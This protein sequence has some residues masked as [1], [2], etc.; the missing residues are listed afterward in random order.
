MPDRPQSKSIATVAALSVSL[1]SLCASTA[2]ADNGTDFNERRRNTDFVRSDQ[3]GGWGGTNDRRRQRPGDAGQRRPWW[4]WSQPSNGWWDPEPAPAQHANRSFETDFESDPEAVQGAQIYDYRPDPLVTLGD[5]SLQWTEPARAAVE[6]GDR[7]VGV[8]PKPPVAA[9]PLA[10]AVFDEMA[11]RS[12]GVRVTEP[13]SKAI[14]AF[15][16]ARNF[17]PIWVSDDA[18]RE[19]SRRALDALS[20]AGAEGLDPAEYLPPALGSFSDSLPD[21]GDAEAAARFELGLTAMALRY[22]MHASGGR[23]VPNRLSGY[24]DLNP[25]TVKPAKALGELAASPSPE[26]YLASLHPTHPAYALLKAEL[27]RLEPEQ[28]Q[29]FVAIA[30]GPAL[31]PGAQDERIPSIRARLAQLGLLSPSADPI[32]VS[33]LAGSVVHP[34][35]GE[36]PAFGSAEVAG[37]MNGEPGQV[38]SGSL[39]YDA[40]LEQAVR[41]FQDRSDLQPDGIIGARTIAALNANSDGQRRRRVLSSL[42]RLRWLPRELGAKHVLVNQASFTAAVVEGGRQVWET[43][44]IVGRPNT[45]TSTFSDEIETVVLNPYWGVPGS[46]I[47]HEMLPRLKRDPGYLDREGYEVVDSGGDVVSSSAVDWWSLSPE[48]ITVGV[49]QPPGPQNALGEI[50]FL[51]PNKHSIYMHDTP[52]KP[53]FAKSMRAYSHGCVRVQNPRHFAELLLGWDQA[54]LD[55]ELASG[56]DQ[57]VP[58]DRKVPV[59]LAYFTAWPDANGRIAYHQD[60]YSRDERLELALGAQRVAMQ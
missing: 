40:E 60:V 6:T 18:S 21:G 52:T 7:L 23:I 56:R 47:I 31:R 19:R 44:V 17:A 51:F 48:R 50:K 27:A 57:T 14:V 46:I 38:D 45:Q 15:Y 9:N 10:R 8:G 13:Q 22:A 53:L 34:A 43:K 5:P 58:L 16:A 2:W 35:D 41:A 12:S 33:S 54:R 29:T 32:K 36:H 37:A 24:H 26:A 20:R 42:E 30:E 39:G 25:P 1:L 4:Q 55:A 28:E 11:G 3:P 59:H 49:R